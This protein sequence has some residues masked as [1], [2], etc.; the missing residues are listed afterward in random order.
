MFPSASPSVDICTSGDLEASQK[1][2][3]GTPGSDRGREA[4]SDRQSAFGIV[5]FSTCPGLDHISPNSSINLLNPAFCTFLEV[6]FL[7]N[8]TTGDV[9]GISKQ[10]IQLAKSR[11]SQ[12]NISVVVVF[13]SE[14]EPCKGGRME[15]SEVEHIWRDSYVTKAPNGQF[16]HEDDDFGPETDVDAVHDVLST[17]FPAD[18]A[19]AKA[20]VVQSQTMEEWLPQR[21]EPSQKEF[22]K[23]LPWTYADALK[24]PKPKSPDSNSSKSSTHNKDI[25]IYE[26]PEIADASLDSKDSPKREKSIDEP[27]PVETSEKKIEVTSSEFEKKSEET[28]HDVAAEVDSADDSEEEWNYIP[29]RNN[30]KPEKNKQIE[31]PERLPDQAEEEDDMSQLNPNA[32]EFVPVFGPKADKVL[33]SSPAKGAEKSLEDVKVPSQKEFL[34]DVSSKPAELDD[35]GYEFSFHENS[36]NGVNV[37]VDSTKAD[38]DDDDD[39]DRSQ[40]GDVEPP[41]ASNPFAE[42]QIQHQMVSDYFS[43]NQSLG[44]RPFDPMQDSMVVLDSTPSPTNQGANLYDFLSNSD[45]PDLLSPID[46]LS[47]TNNEQ[48]KSSSSGFESESG[49]EIDVGSGD[50][51]DLVAGIP[52]DNNVDEAPV[53]DECEEDYAGTNPFNVDNEI[54]KKDVV[55][56]KIPEQTELFEQDE[57]P[58]SPNDPLVDE[59]PVEDINESKP[60]AIFST[61]NEWEMSKMTDD[62]PATV[63]SVDLISGTVVADSSASLLEEESSFLSKNFPQS[64]SEVP[65]FNFLKED[66]EDKPTVHDDHEDLPKDVGLVESVKDQEDSL[67]ILASVAEDK[68]KEESA[69]SDGFEII[70]HDDAELNH[71]REMNGGIHLEEMPSP[72]NYKFDDLVQQQHTVEIHAE[73]PSIPSDFMSDEIRQNEVTIEPSDAMVG[74]E[75]IVDVVEETAAKID[76]HVQVEDNLVSLIETEFVENKEV[77]ISPVEETITDVEQPAKEETVV[78]D[79]IP[80]PELK[81]EECLAAITPRE[82]I[83]QLVA[84]AKDD[85]ASPVQEEVLVNDLVATAFESKPDPFETLDSLPV[86]PSAP[87]SEDF[88]SDAV[89][90]KELIEETPVEP[91]EA[92][93]KPVETPEGTSAEIEA[94]DFCQQNGHVPDVS[95]PPSTPAPGVELDNKDGLIAAAVAAAGVA[96]VAAAAS[97]VSGEAKPAKPEDKTAKKPAAK[98]LASTRPTSA[99]APLAKPGSASSAAK[100][101]TAPSVAAKAPA[102]KTTAAKPLSAAKPLAAKT[103]SYCS[104]TCIA[105]DQNVGYICRC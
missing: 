89:S 64:V 29:G 83:D 65:Q 104:Q 45:K 57:T 63:D 72:D 26:I 75:M 98:P 103:T 73:R 87:L 24:K 62:V 76:D 82:M 27:K 100:K 90:N 85:V 35:V 61:S 22:L 96:S 86:T 93:P 53:V 46:N 13:L 94:E 11:F 19:K 37:T 95:T 99:K 51:C 20:L 80:E 97:A 91:K 50:K 21:F 28:G 79:L 54:V 1:I 30:K 43:E 6:L 77:V 23:S 102:A 34:D 78:E 44:F 9:G 101:P 67:N 42:D 74:S 49:N 25:I 56:E 8:L 68:S 36:M 70:S 5:Q 105:V 2:I 48:Q 69:E 41:K 16:G 52:H 71:V 12:D 10:L 81:Q 7:I 88:T 3:L 32:A 55:I 18:A 47:N 14:P 92:E 40:E 59:S 15:A 39:S 84:L 33:A 17:G 58:V 38:C 60:P 31:S 4:C 66:S